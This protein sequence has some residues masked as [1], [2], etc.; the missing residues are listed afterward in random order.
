[1]SHS[2]RS[3][4]CEIACHRRVLTCFRHGSTH[5]AAV[6]KALTSKQLAPHL[7]TPFCGCACCLSVQSNRTL[8][9]DCLTWVLRIATGCLFRLQARS[10][11]HCYEE[12][13]PLRGRNSRSSSIHCQLHGLSRGTR[14]QAARPGPSPTSFPSTQQR[15]QAFLWRIASACIPANYTSALQHRAPGAMSERLAR[16]LDGEGEGASPSEQQDSALAAG[17]LEASP[18]LYGE[19]RAAGRRRQRRML[20]H[21]G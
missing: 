12:A 6:R 8:A 18:A 20:L 4:S 17:E 21:G 9:C 7:P 19:G 11:A 2:C 3:L 1:M 16:V 10:S 15:M 13:E 14:S 5:Q